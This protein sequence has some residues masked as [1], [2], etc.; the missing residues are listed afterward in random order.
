MGA[1]MYPIEIN[2]KRQTIAFQEIKELENDSLTLEDLQFV[3]DDC[4]S[5]EPGE[6]RGHIVIVSRNRLETDNEFETRIAREESYMTEY[7]KRHPK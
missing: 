4:F 5:V 7:N 6:F 1:Y 2:R 3:G